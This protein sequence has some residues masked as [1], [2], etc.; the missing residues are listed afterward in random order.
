MFCG[1]ILRM[2]EALAMLASGSTAN[3]ITVLRT[4]Y[5]VRDL[6]IVDVLNQGCSKGHALERWARNRGIAREQVMAIG[7]NYNDIEMLAF[8]GLPFIMGNA[9][10]ELRGHGWPVTRSNAEHGVAAA[11]EQVLGPA[12][13]T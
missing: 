5:P 13:I 3:D 9:S 10:E 11:I 7:D 4:E 12:V 6:S 1:P 2:H 8:A